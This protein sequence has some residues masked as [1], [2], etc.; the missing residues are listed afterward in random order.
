MF[1][2]F[3]DTG[4]SRESPIFILG[5]GILT[6]LGYSGILEYGILEF[7]LRYKFN[8]FWDIGYFG[9]FILGY[10]ILPTPLTKPR[11]CISRVYISRTYF[12]D[13]V[14]QN[15]S[16]KLGRA[17]T[18]EPREKT[19]GTPASTAWLVSHVARAGQARS[20]T[21]LSVKGSLC[22]SEPRLRTYF[23]ISK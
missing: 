14:I 10:G 7:I 23:E 22:G 6:L 9:R 3:W 1:R 15:L 21:R 8:E 5:Y 11:K 18:G 20:S 16:P 17:K 4:Y 12:P 2:V 13:A 19:P